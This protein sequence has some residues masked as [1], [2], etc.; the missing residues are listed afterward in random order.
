MTVNSSTGRIRSFIKDSPFEKEI[1]YR[2]GVQFWRDHVL[3]MVLG[4]NAWRGP[5]ISTLARK[6]SPRHKYS[7]KHSLRVQEDVTIRAIFGRFVP[8]LLKRSGSF[9][10]RM[11]YFR[12]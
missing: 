7:M 2:F 5:E 12:N 1:P 10:V 3:C 11:E 8:T 4:D 6:H 9:A